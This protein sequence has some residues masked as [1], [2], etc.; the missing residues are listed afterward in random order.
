MASVAQ[1]VTILSI[2]ALPL[3]SFPVQGGKQ[4]DTDRVRMEALVRYAETTLLHGRD[5]YGKEHTP[6][7]VDA[8]E[9]STLKAPEM[10]YVHRLGGP[11]PRSKQPFQP[12]ISSNLAYQGNLMRFLVGMSNLTGDAKYKAAYMENLRYYFA[13]YAAPNGLLQM[14]HH[15]WVNLNSD[16][17]DGNDWPA[18]RSGHE[19]K[20]DYP[21]YQIFW[22]SDPVATRRMMTAHWDA[23]LQ[24]WGFMNFTRHGS[25]VKE[26]NE[27][28]VWSQPI[29]EPIKGIV[30]GNL[31]FFDSG[32]DI[33]YAG[34][35]LGRLNNDARP[36][37]WA[38]RLYARYSDSAPAETGLPPWHHTSLRN[39]GTE[40]EPVPEYALVN[41]GS[42]GFMNNGGVAMLRIGEELGEKGE[43][44][45]E[46]MLKHLKAYA[47][48]CYRPEVNLMR[49]Y[50][51]DGTDLAE[52]ARKNAK[53][54][55]PETDPWPGWSPSPVTIT[56]YA[57]CYRQ[58]GDAE[59][60]EALRAM[61]RGNDLGDIGAPGGKVLDLNLA[62]GQSSY[63]LIFPLV[64]LFRATKERGYL[65]LARS[66]AD[67]A[68]R[69]HFRTRE[70]LFTPSEL[71]RTA[72]QC[73]AEPLAYLTL[74]AALRGKLDEVPSYAGSNEGEAVPYLRPLKSRP[75]NP[76]VSHLAYSYSLK[77]VCD[78]LLPESSSDRE[79]PH[80][81]WQNVRKATDEAIVTFPDILDGPVIIKGMKDHPE[82]RN[83]VSAMVID[84]PHGYTFT[85]DLAGT[86]DLSLTVLRGEHAWAP[87]ST[88]TT[89]AW[90]STETY[91]LIMDVAQGAKLKFQG[92]AQEVEGAYT[93]CDGAG[94]VKK[95]EGVV[96]LT[97]D[98]A[99]IYSPDVR[100][101]RGYRAPTLIQE[102][103]LL[104]NN[105]SG[106][107]VS[108]KS[109]VQVDWGATLG[110]NG[111]IG[112]GGSS[113]EV[114]VRSGGTIA[115]GDGIGTL[116]L[117]DGLQLRDGARLIFEVGEKADLLRITGGTFRGSN[118]GK[119]VITIKD[120]GG[121]KAGRSYDLIDFTGASFVGVEAN[122]F[123]L[124]KSQNFQGTFH[125]VGTRLQ[126]SVFAP[127][128]TP[129]T[130]PA[131][132]PRP[133]PVLAPVVAVD[134]EPRRTNF[135][136]TG[137]HGGSWTDRTRWKGGNIPNSKE[138][139]W[140]QYQFAKPRRI[141]GVQ[142]YWFVNGRDRKLPERWRVLYHTGKGWQ[143][144]E[145]PGEYSLEVD[146]FNEVNFRPVTT[147]QL[148]LEVDLQPGVSAGVQEWRVLP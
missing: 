126:F 102:G 105:E 80:M 75:Y 86:G 13:H 104:V 109:R 96:E 65:E 140:V 60:W 57:I 26:L 45:R 10:M 108:P 119:V 110:G 93:W 32:S 121:M 134:R 62:T 29:T 100:S 15:R 142:V 114:V 68:F 128:L 111:A 118:R 143:P 16:H 84:S 55:A 138:P 54:G 50:L 5:T 88:W 12:V 6:L 48:I 28:T 117:R 136:W 120:A 56:A 44:Y 78:D 69:K 125:L 148:R 82:S 131:V 64:E 30:P 67:N 36:L 51:I 137:M 4:A 20:R 122:D 31:T 95:G 40:E 7:F 24:D 133:E 101:N 2:F 132:P 145:S 9:V 99:P 11:G 97:A 18:G 14:G 49:Q 94:I 47:K 22:E 27:E 123:R 77:A 146:Q 39:F 21:Y 81:S 52:R 46:T 90:S 34:A 72:N 19:M 23:H 3:L 38:Q 85:G 116:T 74:E 71:H 129:E 41:A 8:L 25:Y 79:V 113:A 76:T 61:C 63:L 42:A 130:A 92:R 83:S 59:I 33:I 107:G 124:D 89:R 147:G 53:P 58:S 135:I 73:S 17:W 141:S 112:L 1:R 37:F 35:Q 115:P 106:S 91:D 144:V 66:V 70:A 139:E 98:Y 103:L 127:R 87:D 43:F